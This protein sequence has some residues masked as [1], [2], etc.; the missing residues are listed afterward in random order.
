[1]RFQQPAIVGEMLAGVL[2]GPSVFA[3]VHASEA[4]SGI[5]ELAVF[6][7]VLSAGLEMKF[8]DVVEAFKGKGII[9]GLLGFVIPLAAGMLT[10]WMFGLD[11]NRS[12]F[13]GLCI[14]ITA[15]PVAVGILQSFNLL[16]SDIAKYSIATAVLNDV[17]A[18]MI[19]GVILGL[20]EQRSF[21][22]VAIS[23]LVILWKLLV[24]GAVIVSLNWL[25]E[26]VY[27]WG[28]H[29]E[30]IPERLVQW[31][32]NDALFGIVVVFV[33]AFGTVSEQLGFHFVIGAFFGALLIDRKF[34]VAERYHVLDST[35]RSV[36][37]GF[38]APIFFLYLGLEFNATEIP[39]IWFAVIVLIVSMVTKVVAGWVGSRM[40]KLPPV[41]ALGIGIIL[42]GRGVMELVI[43]SIAYERGLIDQ[44]LFSTLVL[45]G[46]ITTLITP[47][48][49]RKYVLPK[50]D[51]SDFSSPPETP[52]QP[53]VQNA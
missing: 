53:I 15:L 33:L 49:F 9:I 50:L 31:L 35:L 44:G 34:F 13:L 29:V 23:V 27:D 17:L 37:D 4:L 52:V 19:M 24:L 22:A 51:S 10:G 3:V 11:V 18:L 40:I 36:S 8:A 16:N 45:M 1:M 32:G 48:L 21:D 28:F 43:A 47:I 5:S 6:L 7:V 42:N 26:K 30:R 38:L 20:P 12:V 25:L 14:A 39:S 2:L 41:K 46:V